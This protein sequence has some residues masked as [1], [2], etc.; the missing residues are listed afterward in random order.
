MDPYSA[1]PEIRRLRWLVRFAVLWALVI[2]GRLFSLQV[3]R[4]HELDRAAN[5]QQLR[6]REIA[7]PRGTIKDRNGEELAV[8]VPVDSLAVNP[9]KLKDVAMASDLLGRVL[10]VNARKLRTLIEAAQAKNSGFLWIKRKLSVDEAASLR[11][12]ARETEW[13]DLRQESRREYP[14]GDLAA[15]VIGFLAT[16]DDHETGASGV[17]LS[18]QEDLEGVPG[19]VRVLTDV[20]HRGIDELETVA[21]V[22][23]CNVALTLDARIQY[24]ADTELRRAVRENNC[25]SGTLM[26]MDPNNGDILAMASVPSFDPNKPLRNRAELKDRLNRT[27]SVVSD[28]GSVFKMF[29]IAAALECT[30]LRANSLINCGNGIFRAGG[31]TIR[32]THAYGMLSLEQVIWKSSNVGAIR[33]GIEVGKE[34]LYRYLRNFGFGSITGVNLPGESAGLLALFC[35]QRKVEPRQVWE[36]EALTTEFQSLLADFGVELSWPDEVHP[37]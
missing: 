18:L 19:S 14:H 8:S 20:N 10:N 12:L 16:V 7:A 32:D 33:I 4:H 31:V 34:N 5:N 11:L 37:L 26:V 13:I 29:T 17:E 25:L 3:L 22:A 28:P 35:H 1:V 15:N 6:D 30:R 2:F 27:V 24:V 23:G 9:R 21:P 36:S